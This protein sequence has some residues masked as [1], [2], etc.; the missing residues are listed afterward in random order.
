MLS[1]AL[2]ASGL[3]FLTA[4]A[5]VFSVPIQANDE[6]VSHLLA[7]HES[8]SSGIFDDFLK[9]RRLRARGQHPLDSSNDFSTS[10]RHR[11]ELWVSISHQWY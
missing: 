10:G 2:F 4:N 1:I 11:V 3:L 9:S 5:D 7:Q 6:A 8:G